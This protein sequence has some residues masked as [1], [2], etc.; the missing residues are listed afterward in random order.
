[1]PE[2]SGSSEKKHSTGVLVASNL[3]SLGVGFGLGFM[4]RDIMDAAAEDSATGSTSSS[5]Q[6]TSTGK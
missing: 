3:T 4:A 6:K 1:M 2:N 5:T